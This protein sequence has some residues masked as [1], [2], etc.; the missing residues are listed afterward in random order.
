MAELGKPRSYLFA[1]P[2]DALSPQ[3]ATRFERMIERRLHGE[4]VAYITGS[5]EFWSLDLCVNSATLVPRPE[6]ELLVEIALQQIDRLSATTVLDLGTG[7]GA[8]ALAIASERPNCQLIATDVSEEALDIARAN[9]DRLGI[10]NIEFRQGDW[11]QPVAGD[12]FAII[13]SNP[14]YIEAADPVLA[15][16]HSEPL[17]A[18]ASGPDGLDDIRRLGIDCRAIIEPDGMLLL[19]HGAAQETQVA[20]ILEH[21]N[22]CDIQCFSDLAGLPRITMAR[23]PK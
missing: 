23:P 19:E 18:L 10:S 15:N 6:T 7:S 2:D 17:S 20:A 4:P 14:P 11:T 16:L 5:K 22:W 1:H 12:R 8:V 3:D 13:V 21:N 9:A